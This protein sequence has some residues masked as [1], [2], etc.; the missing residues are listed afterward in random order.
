[1]PTETAPTTLRPHTLVASILAPTTEGAVAALGRLPSEVGLAEVRL[2][3]LWPAVPEAD[4]AT[5]DLL[6][7]ADAARV[8]LLATLR[9][10]RQGGKFEGAEQVRLGLLQTALRAGFAFADLEMDGLDA[11][12]RMGL[13]RQDGG[14]VASSHWPD[15]PCRSDGLNAL[16][17]MQD[18]SAAY[19]KLAFTAGAFPDLLRAFELTRTHAERGGH[20]SVSTLVHGGAATR[21]LLALVGNRATYGAA[22]GLPPAA[23]GQPAAADIAALWRHW[24]LGP[25]DLDLCAASPG[26]WLAVLGAPVDHS[27]S[28]R[29]HN[30]ALRAA[31]RRERYGALEVPASASALRL[32]LHV[33]PRIGMVGASVTAPH[34]VDAARASQGDASVQRTGAANCLRWQGEAVHSTNTDFSALKRLL[35]PHVAV[36]DPALVLGSGGSA[37]AAIAALQDLGA[38][39]AFTSRDPARADAVAKATGTIWVPWGQREHAKPKVVVQATPLGAQSSDAAPFSAAGLKVAVELVYANG[40]TRFQ[41]DAETAGATVIGG[42]QVLVAQA[43]DAYRFWF[44]TAPDVPAM[45]AALEG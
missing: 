4:R 1:M 20:P 27:L 36:G 25:K 9:P 38:R 10:K 43:E 16:L 2:D 7:I 42:R 14:V 37:R 5:D 6:A 8:P 15:T 39:V 23:P 11:S 12:G 34:K 32:F 45:T 40:P 19:D 31:N 29:I 17:Q 24:G 21:A 33:A 13:L 35:A 28:P 3:G 41:T 44:G 18:L 22:P 30:A 26:P